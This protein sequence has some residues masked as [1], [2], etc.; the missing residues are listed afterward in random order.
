MIMLIAWT[1]ITSFPI[2]NNKKKQEKVV[3]I[4]MITPTKS[5]FVLKIVVSVFR[6]GEFAFEVNEREMDKIVEFMKE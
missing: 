5:L 4:L 1:I 6:N 2:T 3:L